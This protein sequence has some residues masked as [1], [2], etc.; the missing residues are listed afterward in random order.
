MQ[1]PKISII[2]PVYNML[3]YI[4]PCIYSVHDQ[5]VD[6]EHIVVDGGSIDGT[7]ELLGEMVFVRSLS[8]KDN[9]MYDALNK[10]LAMAKG[11]IIGHLNADEQYLPGVLS[12]V[13]DFFEKNPD[14]DYV[15]GDFLVIDEKGKLIA[16]RKS[17]AP[18]WPFFFSN[19][20]YTFTCTLFYRKR[21]AEQ[22]QY[23]SQLKSIADVDFFYRLQQQGFRGV[24]LRKFMATFMH[25]GNNL[26]V[27]PFSRKERAEYE[28]RLPLWLK[29]ARPFLKIG[30]FSARVFFKTF[31]HKGSIE[32][33]IYDS[34]DCHKRK[35]SVVEKPTWK[36]M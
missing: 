33:Q 18:F 4:R 32:Y 31:W 27:L 20:L 11:N 24:H 15:V 6:G 10:G 8:E 9:G 36:W 28:K 22:L 2:T 23:D 14:V 5:S 7:K 17:F 35:T 26:S 30:F 21:V 3:P 29:Y 25:T 16:Y 13:V 1:Q 12:Y 19:Y 34:N